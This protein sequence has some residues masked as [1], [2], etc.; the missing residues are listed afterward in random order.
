M[1]EYLVANE[2]ARVRF[3]AGALFGWMAE[4]SKAL[5]LGSNLFGGAGSNPA[6]I[7][8]FIFCGLLSLGFLRVQG[9]A[10][11]NEFLNKSVNWIG[12]V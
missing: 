8:V 1:V 3:P 12:F 7:I 4:W 9:S 2:V 10:M 11:I 6:P 5:D